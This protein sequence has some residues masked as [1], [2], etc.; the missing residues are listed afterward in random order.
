MQFYSKGSNVQREGWEKNDINM[1]FLGN[2]TTGTP[3]EFDNPSR[4]RIVTNS[5]LASNEVKVS[6][7]FLLSLR[8]KEII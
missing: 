4:D 2:R 1:Y 3:T 8:S 5:V 7:Q 6:W